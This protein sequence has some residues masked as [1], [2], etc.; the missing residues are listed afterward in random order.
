MGWGKE[1]TRNEDPGE[2]QGGTRKVLRE[3]HEPW[4]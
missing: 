4:G 2:G 1:F 3:G